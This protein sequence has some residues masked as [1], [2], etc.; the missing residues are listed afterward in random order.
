M[1]RVANIVPFPLFSEASGI[2]QRHLEYAIIS[3]MRILLLLII[4]LF[5]SCAPAGYLWHVSRGQ[6][7]I[8][9]SRKPLDESIRNPSIPAEDR[10]KLA[11]IPDVKHFGVQSLGLKGNRN[12]ESFV[13]LNRAY[14]TLVLSAAPPVSLDVFRWKFPIVG[15]VPYKGFFEK[16]LA[17]QERAALAAQ[18]YDVY[19]RSASAFSTLGWFDDPILS[20]MLNLDEASLA[21]TVLHEMT[22]ATVY[23]S[24][25]TEFNETLATFVGNQGSI[26]FLAVRYGVG[27]AQVSRAIHDLDDDQRFAAFIKDTLKELRHIYA[28]DASTPAKLVAKAAWIGASKTRFVVEVM[29]RFH[30]PDNFKFFPDAV[31]NNASLMA[32]DAYYGDLELFKKLY[33]LRGEPLKDF[34][35]YLRT[36]DDLDPRLRLLR[37]SGVLPG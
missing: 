36:W 32:R 6:L 33:L 17:D 34:I 27:A 11:L 3:R 37:E 14:A 26:E 13:Q 28:Q 2:W 7:D 30:T 9:M 35:Q 4:A 31:W 1:K 23:F 8:L 18:G 22:H 29:P 16:E 15:S 25:H 21:N 19:L 24:D 10:K 5:S 12:F 20:S